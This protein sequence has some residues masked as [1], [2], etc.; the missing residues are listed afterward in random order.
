[1]GIF[2]LFRGVVIAL[3]ISIFGISY[4]FANSMPDMCQD[5]KQYERTVEYLNALIDGSMLSDE[6]K[7]E[8]IVERDLLLKKI[9]LCN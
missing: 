2:P 3:L 6:D 7:V 5:A 4:S 1:M 8:L 9:S